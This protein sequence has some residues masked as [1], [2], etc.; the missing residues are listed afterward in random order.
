M[1]GSTGQTPLYGPAAIAVHNDG[2]VLRYVSLF[3]HF[4]FVTFVLGFCLTRTGASAKIRI[5]DA[6]ICKII[7]RSAIL[8]YPF[9]DFIV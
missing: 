4:V 6:K 2:N 1:T 5:K 8:A 7:R 9:F 3:A